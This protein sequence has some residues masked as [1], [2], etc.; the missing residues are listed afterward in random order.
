[1]IGIEHWIAGERRASAAADR[2]P[3]SDPATGQAYAECPRGHGLDVEAA[4]TAAEAAFPAWS[5][6]KPSERAR[7]LHR[8]ADAIEARFGPLGLPARKWLRLVRPCGS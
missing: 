6:L 1:M 4:V 7:W 5:A 2:L 3:V 8:L